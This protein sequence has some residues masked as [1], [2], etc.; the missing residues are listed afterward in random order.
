MHKKK[1]MANAMGYFLQL[2]HPHVTVR[3]KCY[4]SLEALTQ[5]NEELT[6]FEVIAVT[7]NRVGNSGD[8]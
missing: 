1:P 2:F 8:F 4:H 7:D 3:R 6:T 5:L